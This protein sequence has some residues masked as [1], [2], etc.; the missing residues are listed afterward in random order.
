MTTE[1]TEKQSP[2][3]E[4]PPK[5]SKASKIKHDIIQ[6]GYDASDLIGFSVR[7]NQEVD[8]NNSVVEQVVTVDAINWQAALTLAGYDNSSSYSI[9]E[10]D[11]E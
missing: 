5:K 3:V 1:N 10:I 11:A 4:T 9:E 6:E 2:A 7:L 8:V